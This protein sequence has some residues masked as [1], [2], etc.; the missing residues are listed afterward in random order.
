[1]K[2]II[3]VGNGTYAQMMKKYIDLTSFGEVCAYAVDQDFIHEKELDKVRVISFDEMKEQFSCEDVALVMGIGY[4][5]M[6]NVRKRVFEQCKAWG[7]N[8]EN[9][10]H[11][12]AIV[13]PDIIIGEGNNILEGVLIEAGCSIGNANLLFG[14]SM[15]GHDSCVGNYNTFAGK[16]MIAGCVTVKN[17]VFLGVSSAVKD[18]VT[19]NNYVLLGAM[20][21]GYKDMEE[22]AVAVPAKSVVLKDKKSTEY[23]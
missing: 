21:Y 7:Y 9:Y 2:K 1:M 22:Y 5:Q 19:L 13:A 10:I 20:A 15:L 11:P 3:I 6:S 8:F 23:L 4:T 14:G 12:T 16:S 18:H 17:N